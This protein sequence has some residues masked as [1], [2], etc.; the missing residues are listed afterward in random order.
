VAGLPADTLL[1]TSR[2][3]DRL[4]YCI[5]STGPP[6]ARA[7]SL[8]GPLSGGCRSRRPGSGS[9]PFGAASD[10][11][12]PRR[13]C[14]PTLRG[15]RH[16]TGPSKHQRLHW[17]SDCYPS[18]HVCQHVSRRDHR[19]GIVFQRTRSRTTRS[20]APRG[21]MRS[22]YIRASDGRD[23]AQPRKNQRFKA[24]GRLL[25]SYKF[26]EKYKNILRF[27]DKL[28]VSR[29]SCQKVAYV[30]SE[31][32]A[33]CALRQFLALRA[34]SSLEVRSHPE[35]PQRCHFPCSR[36]RPATS[37]SVSSRYRPAH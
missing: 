5:H 6:S 24:V 12:A 21:A 30:T 37:F 19:H 20:P 14:T 18:L 35:P 22:I 11:V 4:E 23:A 15:L 10:A 7:P 8:P 13:R 2:P 16:A 31:F 26:S 1:I 9:R 27:A 34:A 17:R 32:V 25:H 36:V 28:S 29:I 3:R 33:S